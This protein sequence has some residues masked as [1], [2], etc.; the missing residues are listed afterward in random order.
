M[1]HYDTKYD[2]PILKWNKTDFDNFLFYLFLSSLPA[3]RLNTLFLYKIP[4]NFKTLGWSRVLRRVTCRKK[5]KKSMEVTTL[6]EE[7]AQKVNAIII[8]TNQ[9][10]HTSRLPPTSTHTSTWTLSMLTVTATNEL[11][12]TATTTAAAITIHTIESDNP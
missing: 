4:M 10:I 1:I 6:G 3:I 5:N 7:N 8:K 9:I 2:H 12:L 11:K